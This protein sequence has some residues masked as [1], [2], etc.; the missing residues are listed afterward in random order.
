MTL[1]LY[2]D[3][4]LLQARMALTS[5]VLVA[6]TMWLAGLMEFDAALFY[7]FENGFARGLCYSPK[8]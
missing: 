8:F 3:E 6:D 4:R 2:Y 5:V 7:S 1:L